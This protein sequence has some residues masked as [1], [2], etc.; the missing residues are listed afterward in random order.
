MGK[1]IERWETL[2][3]AQET[4]EGV[5]RE[6]PVDLQDRCKIEEFRYAEIGKCRGQETAEA[7]AGDGI[8]ERGYC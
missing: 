2:F 6:V 1:G 7:A 4:Q 5:L 3:L 8:I